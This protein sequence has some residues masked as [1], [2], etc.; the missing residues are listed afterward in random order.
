M[1]YFFM[2]L[3]VL[4]AII[5]IIGFSK[6]FNLMSF[7]P[8]TTSISRFTGVLWLLAF[9]LLFLSGILYWLKTDAWWLISL[10][11][12]S[13]SQYLIISNWAD[14][15]FGTIPNGLILFITLFQFFQWK[16]H[17]TY[18]RE[19]NEL[20][21]EKSI[22][23]DELLLEKDIQHLPELV[24]KYIHYTGS[25]GKPKIKNFHVLFSGGIRKN[26][27]SEW[28]QHH[29]EQYSSLLSG[30]RLFF[31]T[32]V[33]KKLPIAGYHRYKNG[34][35]KMD[36]KL[37]SLFKVQYQDGPLM[38]ISESVTFL[39]DICLMA[40]AALIQPIFSWGQA[41][42]NTVEVF[43]SLHGIKVSAWLYFNDQG[44]LKD[45]VS[46]DRYA[47]QGKDQMKKIKWSTP[48]YK[49]GEFNGYR[50]CSEAG[51][52]YHYSTNPLTYATFR[53][54]QLEYNVRE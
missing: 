27:N 54:S 21:L 1:K 46:G 16:F 6:A 22:H 37:F 10:I 25:L 20:L 50:L 33:M 14:A 4:H 2:T 42:G 48:V 5:H 15:R 44:Q 19:V 7:I 53:I 13:L 51:A 32:A 24:K 29:T 36:I 28:M 23:S 47:Y 34:H 52:I 26:E 12:I 43:L 3:I 9:L 31:M 38:D 39:N 49:Y 41:E 8:S 11:A 30:T 35:A 18:T 40:P 45:F 17:R